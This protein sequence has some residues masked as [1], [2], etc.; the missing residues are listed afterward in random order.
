MV[1][2]SLK[3]WQKNMSMNRWHKSTEGIRVHFYYQICYAY[4]LR[5]YN[6][7]IHCILFFKIKIIEVFRA[8]V[9]EHWLFRNNP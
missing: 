9:K 7:S 5:Q 1:V 8:S 6:L 3:S 4:N 2:V